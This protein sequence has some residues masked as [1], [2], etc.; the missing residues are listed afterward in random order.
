MCEAVEKNLNCDETDLAIIRHTQSGLPLCEE[1][2]RAVGQSLD[3]DPEVV[4]LRINQMLERGIIR[5]IAV[6]PNHFALGYVSNG[7][8][9]WD[10]ADE[11]IDRTGEI[12]GSLDFVSHCYQRIRHLPDWP[13]NLFAMVHG[14]DRESTDGKISMITELLGDYSRGCAVLY[15]KRILKKTGL[16][17]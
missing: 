16:R 5:R 11:H 12:I 9:V 15:S 6:V 17:I 4:M 2:Y 14:K 8:A 1:P 7:M 10:V 13:Y 3:I